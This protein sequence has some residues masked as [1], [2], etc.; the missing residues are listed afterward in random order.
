M[1]TS[2]ITASRTAYAS[3]ALFVLG[4]ICF[5]A[6]VGIVYSVT[7]P[8]ELRIDSQSSL[9]KLWEARRAVRD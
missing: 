2:L 9:A 1:P 8:E 5:F 3:A 7:N 4:G 6:A